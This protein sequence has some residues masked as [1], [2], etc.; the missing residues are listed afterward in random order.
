MKNSI[1]SLLVLLLIGMN[2]CKETDQEVD[3]NPNVLS[4]KDYVVAEDAVF[5]IINAFFKGIHDTAVINS[6]F[7]Y[8]D[9]CSVRYYP[10]ED[11][12]SYG[13]G[14]VDRLCQDNK[15]RRGR[16]MA[17]FDGQIFE[18]GVTA[19]IVTDSLFVDDL[20]YEATMEI[21]NSGL[22]TDNLPEFQVNVTSSLVILPDTNKVHGISLTAD[23]V[24]VWD[25]GYTTPEVHEDDIYLVEGTAA[26]LSSDLYNF[27]V[28]IQDP[29]R[30]YLDCYWIMFGYS[31]ITVSEAEYP[32]GNIDYIMEDGCF[33][34]MY[35]YFNDNLFYH[36]IK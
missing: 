19:F 1:I 8:I 7:G 23:F 31:Q 4:A 5:E 30:N 3:Y 18:E 22:N 33:N 27:S 32:T 36:M 6:G 20:L 15:F 29:L 10:D 26:G 34:E 35:F 14:E 2:S 25:E 13:Y 16:F 9:A 28:Q 11:S 17:N 21:K 12:M 24:M